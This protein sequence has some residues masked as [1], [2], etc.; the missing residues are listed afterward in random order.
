MSFT[1]L[2]MKVVATLV[3]DLPPNPSAIELGNQ[4]FDPTIK[5]SLT[6]DEDLI[7][8]LVMGFL[9]RRGRPFDKAKLLEIMAQPMEA[10]KPHTAT[11]YKALGL[12]AYDAIDVNSLYGSIVMDLNLDL[13]ERS[14]IQQDLRFCDQQWHGRA[15]LQPIH[16]VQK[17]T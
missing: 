9:E 3:D 17:R 11:Y 7:F 4:T 16:G 8:P 15:H 13:R 1:P 6:K 12:S 5:G 2:M 10:Q 14:R